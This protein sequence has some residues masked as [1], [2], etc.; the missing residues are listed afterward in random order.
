MA[1][2]AV[3]LALCASMP[4]MVPAIDCR[5]DGG[6]PRRATR[7]RAS[8]GGSRWRQDYSPGLVPARLVEHGLE[9]PSGSRRGTVGVRLAAQPHAPARASRSAAVAAPRAAGRLDCRGPRRK[10]ALRPRAGR[11]CV[12]AAQ[13]AACDRR[14]RVPPERRRSIEKRAAD[15]EVPSGTQ[16]LER[17]H[18][19]SCPVCGTGLLLLLFLFIL[20]LAAAA[21]ARNVVVSVDANLVKLQFEPVWLIVQRVGDV[22]RQVRDTVRG[23]TPIW[24]S[25][26]VFQLRRDRA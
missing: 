25:G 13:H 4:P 1:R 3:T 17:R 15:A 6:R 23:V 7:A 12:E 2:A 22:V 9:R 8:R 20:L 11:A 19:S 10:R 16:S 5:D 24:A 14:R 21:A 26:Y 18:G